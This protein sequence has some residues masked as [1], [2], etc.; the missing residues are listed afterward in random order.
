[1]HFLDTKSGLKEEDFFFFEKTVEWVL[2]PQV[3]KREPDVGGG[4]GREGNKIF[5][6]VLHWGTCGCSCE[7]TRLMF[8]PLHHHQP[9]GRKCTSGPAV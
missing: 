1:L 2:A 3:G 8:S 9:T 7:D 5:V 4:A 6:S